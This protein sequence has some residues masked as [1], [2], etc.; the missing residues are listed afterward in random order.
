MVVVLVPLTALLVGLA[1][2]PIENQINNE[3]K[4]P[5][6]KKKSYE[7]IDDLHRNR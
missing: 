2:Q 3:L 4:A 7:G 5:P 6:E 1:C